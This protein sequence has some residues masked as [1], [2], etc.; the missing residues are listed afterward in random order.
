MGNFGEAI[1]VTAGPLPSGLFSDIF[2]KNILPYM[3]QIKL[4]YFVNRMLERSKFCKT[5]EGHCLHA[6][7]M[8][9][10]YADGDFCCLVSAHW[11][12]NNVREAI[13]LPSGR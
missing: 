12:V 1:A 11:R 10:F 13:F 5:D 6:L 8:M 9:C 7:K 4:Y 2:Q 3:Q